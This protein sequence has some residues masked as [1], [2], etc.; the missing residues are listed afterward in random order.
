VPADCKVSAVADADESELI[1][2][3]VRVLFVRVSVVARPTKV[4]VAAGSVKVVVPATAVAATVVVPDV[5]P[6]N[7]TVP[8][9]VKVLPLPILRPTDV[10]VPAAAKIASTESKSVLIFVPHVSVLAPTSGLVSNRL[11]VVVSAIFHLHAGTCV[12][13]SELS[14]ISVQVSG[15]S[16]SAVQVSAVSGIAPHPKPII[17]PTEPDAS[18]PIIAIDTAFVT[19]PTEP[20]PS[21]PVM[22]TKEIVSGDIVPTAPV[23]ELPVR[24][25]DTKIELTDKVE[26]LPVIAKLKEMPTVPTLPVATLPSSWID[27]SSSNV[28][29]PRVDELPVIAALSSP[30]P[31]LP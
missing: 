23:D 29:T 4:S 17:V 22:A 28:P 14:D 19:L 10:P 21:T 12:H 30:M 6:E 26:S 27:L 20:V 9:S 2:G 15:V 5:D 3:V 18:T 24:I 1:T 25:G 11:V 7:L 16:A 31:Q 8:A 13:V